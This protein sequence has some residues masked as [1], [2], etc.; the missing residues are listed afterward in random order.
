M[1]TNRKADDSS[2]KIWKVGS[3][4]LTLNVFL[5]Y[6]L[7]DYIE[8][9]YVAL[10]ITVLVFL[11]LIL[12]KIRMRGSKEIDFINTKKS[13][14]DMFWLSRK[15]VFMNK[16][17]LV[18]AVIG[19]VLATTVI[20][21]SVLFSSS[22]K[23]D[24]FDNFIDK[25]DTRG[26]EFAI[27]DLTDINTFNTWTTNIEQ[28]VPDLIKD[29]NFRVTSISSY[30]EFRFPI[31]VSQIFDNESETRSIETLKFKT[32]LWTNETLTFLKQFPTFDKSL[33][34]NPND[35][36]VITSQDDPI[37]FNTT[38][39]GSYQILADSNFKLENDNS[40]FSV[41]NVDQTYAWRISNLDINYFNQNLGLLQAF[42]IKFE[43]LFQ[44]PSLLLPNGKEWDIFNLINTK[45]RLGRLS[46]SNQGNN[47]QDNRFNTIITEVYFD[48]PD[49]RN[50]NL[51]QLK[52]NLE[53]LENIAQSWAYSNSGIVG[54]EIDVESPLR[55]SI[56]DFLDFQGA[57]NVILI[58]ISGMLASIALFL[59]HYSLTLV[60]QRKVRL[61]AIMKNRG[62]SKSQ[63]RTMLFGEALS[64][65]VIAISVGM[66]LSIPWTLL[67]LR[68]SGVLEF[69]GEPIPLSIPSSWLW[70][71]PLIG[72]IIAIDLNFSSIY[73]LSKTK[74]EEGEA[75]EETQEPFWQRMYLDVVLVSFSLLFWIAV[76]YIPIRNENVY[77]L[78][79]EGFSPTMMIILIIGAPLVFARYFA[80]MISK[81]S[82]FL[83]K[84]QG[85]IIALATRN[86][87]KNK[88]SI[89]RLASLLM[90]GIMLSF[91]SIITPTT[92]VSMGT[93]SSAYDL[94]A[95]IYVQGIDSS[96][97]T[98]WGYLDVPGVKSYTDI[99]Q[100]TIVGGPFTQYSILGINPKN[101]HQSAYWER[102]YDSQEL[103]EI[104][105]KIDTNVSVGLQANVIDALGLKM[106]DKIVIPIINDTSRV[107]YVLDIKADFDYFPTLVTSVPVQD[108]F[109]NYHPT[110]LPMLVDISL[111][112]SINKTLG[113]A[114]FG[115]YVN[116]ND[117]SN[118]DV[119]A[120]Q[121]RSKFALNPSVIVTSIEDSKIN[122]FDVSE[123]RILLASLQGMLVITLIVSIIAIAF[124]SIITL[125]E[126][127][128]EIGVLRAMGMER[129]QIFLLLITESL[130]LV[131]FSI[132]FGGLVGIVIS[133]NL[134]IFITLVLQGA[135]QNGAVP[136]LH[137]VI[138]W[139]II[140][141]FV[142]V[143]IS[144]SVLVAAIPAYRTSIKE[145][146]NIL[147][148]E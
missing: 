107:S 76:R 66:I 19:L 141:Q 24:S 120:N 10:G 104:T 53:E 78:I 68:T 105:S 54:Y 33:K 38:S 88:F 79:V 43:K 23:Q 113:S 142:L 27:S 92:L 50:V 128:K 20:S 11:L 9:L 34:F 102:N 14:R 64:S 2:D 72:F 16:K 125:T 42:D 61:I 91:L 71:I 60:E 148:E 93:E 31:V 55:N 30:A 44:D 58:F 117:K 29:F 77:D 65:A 112:K 46:L 140:F 119:I 82:N 122:F 57:F 87:R 131:L 83:W 110:D 143:L 121:I 139:G 4:I 75:T 133:M 118:V 146:G 135:N 94:G 56:E 96:N 106:N 18:T 45:P 32:R 108:R 35:I 37:K 26:L 85:G 115:A 6:L 138:P 47:D 123:T 98:E 137:L 22:Y 73:S 129:N 49:L 130:I 145:T 25:A 7:L 84:F 70:R 12:D 103:S 41:V 62:T 90:I 116:V 86:M 40:S 101:F 17:F 3:L 134:F 48:L 67:S 89:S 132:F 99:A 5:I 136:P 80:G 114:I 74:I 147:R 51:L 13:F 124:F 144:L 109:G 81:I 15:Y 111:V 97:L 126:R 52:S 36:I 21:Q 28:N 39:T 95:D 100:I 63:L 8:I 59:V 69:S 1:T 127:K